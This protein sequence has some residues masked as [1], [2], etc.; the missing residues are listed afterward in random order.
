MKIY[1]EQ[2]QNLMNN[3]IQEKEIETNIFLFAAKIYKLK[4]KNYYSSF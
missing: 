3:I 2:K 1:Q 4:I